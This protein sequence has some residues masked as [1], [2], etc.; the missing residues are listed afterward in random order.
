MIGV[1]A[2]RDAT[3]SDLDRVTD[4]HDRRRARHVVSENARTLAAAAAMD[5]D[6]APELGRLMSDSHV[7]LRDD[8]EVSAPA[9]DA[10]VEVALT[11]PGC[12]GARMTGGGFAGCAVALVDCDEADVF[13]RSVR[14]RYAFEGR[15]AEVWMC[16]PAPGASVT[17]VGGEG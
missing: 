5:R 6:D 1:G 17:Q 10:I 14:E 7:S 2:L 9:L 8:F 15:H 4:E 16:A 11:S 3:V 13:A 12:F